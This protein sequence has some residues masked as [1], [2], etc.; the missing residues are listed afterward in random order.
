MAKSVEREIPLYR[1]AMMALNV[2]IAGGGPAG[3]YLAYLLKRGDARRVVRVFEQNPANATYGFGVVFSERA[4]QFLNDGSTDLV[5]RIEAATE[6]WSGQDI[7]IGDATVHID[8]ARGFAVA[9]LDLLTMLQDLCAGV[10]VDMRFETRVTIEALRDFDVIVAADGTNSVVREAFSGTFGTQLAESS[11]RFAWYGTTTR[12]EC[13]AL[14]FIQTE[15]GAFCGHHYRYKPQMSTFVAE[16]DAAA[17]RGH[18]MAEM[19]EDE[20]RHFSEE[21]FA[22]VLT[23][24]LI[25]NRSAWH[26]WRIY[27][28]ERWH[29][30]NIALIGDALRT[31]HPSI[32]SGTRLAMEDS[33]FLWRALEAEGGDIPAAL[34]AY[35]AERRPIREKLNLAAVKSIEWYERMG[36][37]M[38]MPPYDFVY[39][40]LTRT[41]RMTDERLRAEMPQFMRRYDSQH[42][43]V[44]N[45]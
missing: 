43:A 41:G 25:S 2:A 16:C 30:G 32:G 42:R 15:H 35:E 44:S 8:G 37:I 4:L 45:A 24:P 18:R 36:E 1:G 21:L 23:A 13:N 34:A 38:D 31:A 39:S 9:R 3:L 40:F 27:S 14:T 28:N 22:H 5:R 29:H 19:S 33:I 11:N 7:N 26:P 12:Y 10:G 6:S 17:W 20:R